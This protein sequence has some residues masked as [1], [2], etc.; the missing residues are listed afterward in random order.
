MDFLS[1]SEVGVG[2]GA[3]VEAGSLNTGGVVVFVG[4]VVAAVAA[5]VVVG[6]VFVVVRDHHRQSAWLSS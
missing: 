6:V 4:I 1:G 3:P 5:V 2:V